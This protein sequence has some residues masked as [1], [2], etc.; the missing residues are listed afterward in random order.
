MS[1]SSNR[2]TRLLQKHRSELAQVDLEPI[3]LHMVK[4]RVITSEEQ[5]RV[6]QLPNQPHQIDQLIEILPQKGFN[7]FREFCVVLEQ[8]ASP[9][10]LS[11]LLTDAN[12][13]KNTYLWS[14]GV[15]NF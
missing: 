10:L 3:L 7:A 11:S 9:H 4:K 1:T 8:F 6:L 2:I 12:G 13:E 5:G 15:V 14:L